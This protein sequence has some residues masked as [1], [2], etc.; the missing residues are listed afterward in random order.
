MHACTDITG[1]GLA[2]HGSEM[3]RASGVTLTI[4][5]QPGCRCFDG[6]ARDGGRESFGRARIQPRPLCG[7]R[8]GRGQ[9]RAEIED[10]LY[11]PQTSGG[12]LVA[13]DPGC[14]AMPVEAAFRAA[15]VPAWRIGSRRRGR[16][17]HQSVVNP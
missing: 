14:R 13:A 17:R 7:G 8:P 4:A 10:L 2:G 16:Y 1:F 3:A 12:L 5:A 11:D 9:R 6:V 15:G